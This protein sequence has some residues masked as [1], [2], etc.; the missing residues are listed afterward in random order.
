MISNDLIPGV[1]WHESGYFRCA[2]STICVKG[3]AGDIHALAELA[4]Q[5]GFLNTSRGLY[6]ASDAFAGIEY[7]PETWSLAQH[8][9]ASD[10][11][12]KRS[13]QTALSQLR[14]A[15]AKLP[16]DRKALIELAKARADVLNEVAP[17]VPSPRVFD[18]YTPGVL[19]AERRALRGFA[20]WVDWI[21]P[22]QVVATSA[23]AWNDIDRNPPRNS[24]IHIAAALATSDLDEWVEQMSP[25]HDPV[26]A[27]RV[28]GPAGPIYEI[29]PG[30]HRAHAARLFGLPQ[31]LALVKPAGLP[32]AVRPAD[33]E[34]SAVWSGLRDRGMLEAEVS[35]D[36]WW[37]VR[38][39]VA[40]WMLAS[41]PVSTQINAA[42][43]RLYPGALQEAT[44]LTITELTS[45]EDWKR[46]L[47]GRGSWWRRA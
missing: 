15:A 7:E 11:Q 4:R 13:D 37:Y 22:E 41:P 44:G 47:V 19:V 16:A 9:F 10:F 21:P 18:T 12:R 6:E 29:G 30:T 20:A 3:V 43:E 46:A 42:Y 35:N 31:L 14:V 5:A 1:E 34:T 39:T 33:R 25:E 26:S 2:T 32:V 8:Y 27:K 23:R 45:P 28:E 40:E 38:S 36:N 17:L 24:V